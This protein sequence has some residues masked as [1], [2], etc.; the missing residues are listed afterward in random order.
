[1][2]G[3]IELEETANPN[4]TH[5]LLHHNVTAS[6]NEIDIEN[7]DVEAGSI[8]TCRICLECDGDEDEDL[9]APSMCQRHPQF[10]PSA[11]STYPLAICQEGFG[12]FSHCTDLQ[13]TSFNFKVVELKTQQLQ[14]HG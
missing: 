3:E 4:D 13:S 11:H 9:I 5:P 14:A 1:M 7:D 6:S 2:S 10:V 12:L 8:V